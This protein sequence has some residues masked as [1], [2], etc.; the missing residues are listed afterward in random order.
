[1][2]DPFG[3]ELAGDGNYW[4]GQFNKESMGILQPDG[5]LKQ[6]KDLPNNAHTRYRGGQGQ[7]RVRRDREPGQGRDHQGRQLARSTAISSARPSI[8]TAPAPPP[9]S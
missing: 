4:I 1:M 2:S 8:V 6:F 9:P 3:I 7:R 5:D